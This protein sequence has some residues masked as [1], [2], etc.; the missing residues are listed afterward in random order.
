LL[1]KGAL[2]GAEVRD[3]LDTLK[4]IFAPRKAKST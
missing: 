1:D 4:L 2:Q 3:G